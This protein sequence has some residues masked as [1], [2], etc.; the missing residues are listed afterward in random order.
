MC[1]FH[2]KNNK[3]ELNDAA[4]LFPNKEEYETADRELLIAMLHDKDRLIE[5]LWSE[6][7]A[8]REQ[9]Q[10]WKKN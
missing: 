6:V 4:V 9:E 8:T 3:V 2:I 1:G 10:L 7:K 5:N